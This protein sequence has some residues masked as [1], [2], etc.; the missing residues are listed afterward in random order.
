MV[1]L[2]FIHSNHNV[3]LNIKFY[4]ICEIMGSNAF[5]L[6][7][8]FPN[9]HNSFQYWEVRQESLMFFPCTQKV[10]SSVM[11]WIWKAGEN[12]SFYALLRCLLVLSGAIAKTIPVHMRLSP[13]YCL[14]NILDS[15]L[16]MYVPF[17][18]LLAYKPHAQ[19]A[20]YLLVLL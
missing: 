18:D 20:S 3:L 16:D 10:D 5:V 17:G 7:K 4:A 1:L 12:R 2:C 11:F 8:D 14:Y 9:E 15:V 6:A 13:V 19:L